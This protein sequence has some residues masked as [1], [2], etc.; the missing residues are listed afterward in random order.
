M[1]RIL[2]VV[3]AVGLAAACAKKTVEK[4]IVTPEEAGKTLASALCEKYA[5]CQQGT[6]FNKDQCLQEIGNGLTER[7]KS[8]TE[9]KVDGG[10]LDGCQ[11][12][13]SGAGCD[14][15]QRET[16]PQGCEFLQ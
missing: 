14:I 8:K 6:E 10:M 12:T 1:R 7:L 16:P 15:L 13:I 11:K 2:I 5:G 9:L 4:K 3:V